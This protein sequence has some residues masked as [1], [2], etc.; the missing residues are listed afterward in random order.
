MKRLTVK[1]ENLSEG[2]YVPSEM[3]TIDRNGEADDCTSCM[4]QCTECEQNC[5]YCPIQ[6]CFN[7]LGR[8]EDKLEDGTLIKLPVPI[9]TPVYIL[10]REGAYLNTSKFR[11]SDLPEWGKRVFKTPEDALRVSPDAVLCETLK[12]AGYGKEG[13]Q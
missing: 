2:D 6:K 4:D 11:I 3:C 1:Y 8:L 13:K 10:C 7:K 5:K 9:G 12:A